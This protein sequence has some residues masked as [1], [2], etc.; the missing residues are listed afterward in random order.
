MFVEHEEV[1]PLPDNIVGLG[2]YEFFEQALLGRLQ[3]W[4]TREGMGCLPFGQATAH[5][6][7]QCGAT[8]RVIN[9]V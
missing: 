2:M 5:K 1:N 8:V 4:S 9:F 3:R 7:H 6:L